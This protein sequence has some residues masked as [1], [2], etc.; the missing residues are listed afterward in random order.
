MNLSLALQAYLSRI[1]VEHP[2]YSSSQ[3]LT[4]LI[5]ELRLNPVE[6]LQPLHDLGVD[7][8]EVI[9]HD[10]GRPQVL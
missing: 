10:S 6:L 7:L 5:E 2:P 1:S 4:Q 3:T 9:H 8:V